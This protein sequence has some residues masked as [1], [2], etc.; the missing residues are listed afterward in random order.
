MIISF[1][2]IA[3]TLF[4]IVILLVGLTLAV[5]SDAYIRPKHRRLMLLIIAVIFLLVVE[6]VLD[7]LLETS[8][9]N[10]PLRKVVD[11]IGYS[12]RPVILVLFM[13]I[14][15]RRRIHW[16]AWALV[17]VNAAIH[18]TALF[19]NICFDITPQNT[20]YR[21]GPL[22]FTCHIVSG[23]LLLVLLYLSIR[24]N[25]DEKIWALWL[26]LFNTALIVVAAMM[27]T[28]FRKLLS[29]VSF[30]TAAV[31]V[32]SGFY[33]IWLHQQFVREH[34][35]DL[36]AQQRIQ[37]MISQIQPHFLYNTLSTIQALCDEDPQKASETTGK[38]ATYLRQ[39]IDSLS[40]TGRIPFDKELE[41]TQIYADI[42]MIRFPNI[43]L[44]QDIQDRA[45]TVPALTVQ[46]LVENAIRHGVRIREE[47]VV[48]ISSRRTPD[49][50]EI[51][52][53]DNGKGFD[54]EEVKEAPGAHIGIANV[55]ERIEQMCGG[56]L[57][58]ESRMGEGTTV[59]IRI[60]AEYDPGEDG[61]QS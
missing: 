49:A 50:H 38:F 16:A 43:R 6:N 58:I 40:L 52:I 42:E 30:V 18:M 31:V 55:R 61:G 34:E 56:T 1:Q 23:I 60:P 12:V 26:P 54:T 28:F 20:F 9:L 5:V 25:R 7:H 47:G 53:R 8:W 35:E 39:N 15:S 59:T 45:F 21:L 11:I 29:P 14:V 36:K 19:S 41:H 10:V 27:D 33:Y 48:E 32:C 3:A 4:V 46:P 13:Y 44:V 37:I 17:C 2:E 22:G 57:A 24:E 51:T